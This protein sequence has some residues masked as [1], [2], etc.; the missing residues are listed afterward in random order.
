VKSV[1]EIVTRFRLIGDEST[2]DDA[3][4]EVV[5]LSVVAI[6]L[7]VTNRGVIA[8][9]REKENPDDAWY[10]DA[11]RDELHELREEKRTDAEWLTSEI[12]VAHG[13]AGRARDSQDFR[14]VDVKLLKRRRNVVLAVADRLLELADDSEFLRREAQA[15]QERTHA[16]V[17]EAIATIAERNVRPDPYLTNDERRQ[18]IEDLGRDLMNEILERTRAEKAESMGRVTPP[19]LRRSAKRSR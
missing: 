3:I 2:E 8:M 17:K 10:V 5:R 13:R 1:K 14:A 16:E 12:K 18:R 19:R 4:D 15:C 7:S 9:L 11:V 6:R